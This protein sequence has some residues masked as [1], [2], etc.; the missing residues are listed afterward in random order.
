MRR[1]RAGSRAFQSRDDLTKSVDMLR[2]LHKN[3][4]TNAVQRG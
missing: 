1:R 2:S 3:P 4:A